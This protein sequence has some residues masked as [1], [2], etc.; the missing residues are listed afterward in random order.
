MQA[1][2]YA[3]EEWNDA[4]HVN[5]LVNVFRKIKASARFCYRLSTAARIGSTVKWKLL[6]Y[7]TWQFVQP[8]LDDGH[9]IHLCV[10]HTEPIADDSHLPENLSGKHFPLILPAGRASCKCKPLTRQSV[11]LGLISIQPCMPRAYRQHC[12]SG[13]ISM[14]TRSPFR[15]WHA[16]GPVRIKG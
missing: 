2:Q 10:P 5:K 16:F 4:A 8:L 7:R 6:D 1:Q 11:R 15:R 13:S 14:E 12:R 3:L 9:I